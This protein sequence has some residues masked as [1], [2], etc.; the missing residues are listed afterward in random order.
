MNDNIAELSK[1]TIIIPTF[2][3]YGYL[4][5]LLQ[6]YSSFGLEINIII[7][8]SSDTIQE[9]IIDGFR[10][11]MNI[12]YQTFPSDI[13][14]MTKFHKAAEQVETKYTIFCG[15]DDFIVPNGISESVKFLEL[16]SD[17]SC[18]HGIYLSYQCVKES[19]NDR[20]IWSRVYI[21]GSVSFDKAEQRLCEHIHDYKAPTFY[22]VHRT[23]KLKL[24]L[25]ENNE[26]SEDYRF[27]EIILT[28]LVAIY[29]SIKML[30][31]FYCVREY[32]KNSSGQSGYTWQDIIVK[33][34]FSE[35]YIKTKECLAKHLELNS[36]M[37]FTEALRIVDNILIK[38]IISRLGCRCIFKSRYWIVM[39]VKCLRMIKSIMKK[40]GIFNASKNL[41][42]KLSKSKERIDNMNEN[43]ESLSKIISPHSPYYMDFKKIETI[44]L[45]SQ[46]LN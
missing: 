1:V 14:H 41:V 4:E 21:E 27:G 44:I 31:S 5:R 23:E 35:K 42:K 18:A 38:Y 17:Y 43:K 24:F 25:R 12:N 39:Y 15:D 20:L 2:N 29:G 7:A 36:E 26:I 9:D 22:A 33:K 45:E 32:N 30:D 3:R 16:N 10:N 13:H 8:D 11:K 37:N 28:S 19:I 6:Y 34:D 46:C 40:T